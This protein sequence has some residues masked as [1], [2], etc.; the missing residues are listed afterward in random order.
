MSRPPNYRPASPPENPGSACIDCRFVTD[1]R[2]HAYCVRYSTRVN[3]W[4]VCDD[5]TSRREVRLP[6]SLAPPALASSAGKDLIPKERA[7]DR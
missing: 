1:N 6:E 3:P 7:D 2:C 5:W 4:S